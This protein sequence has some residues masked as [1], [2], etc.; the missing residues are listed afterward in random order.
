NT[1]GEDGP[2]LVEGREGAA[3]RVNEAGHARQRVVR[4]VVDDVTAG[5]RLAR[6]AGSAGLVD[7]VVVLNVVVDAGRLGVAAGHQCGTTRVRVRRIR[8]QRIRVLGACVNQLGKRRARMLGD[9]PV[10]VALVHA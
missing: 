1:G 7:L 6:A 10:K 4:R 2:V 3:W 8:G 5:R 9:V